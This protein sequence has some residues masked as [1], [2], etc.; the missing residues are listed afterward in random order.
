MAGLLA[1]IGFAS[2]W[3]FI[4]YLQ[5]QRRNNGDSLKPKL[6]PYF[7]E[8]KKIILPY[9]NTEFAKQIISKSQDVLK[10]LENLYLSFNKQGTFKETDLCKLIIENY[11]DNFF[12]ETFALI[13]VYAFK[14]YYG[15]QPL[16]AEKFAHKS[17]Q[18]YC[19]DKLLNRINKIPDIFWYEFDIEKKDLTNDR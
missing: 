19:K 18:K 2:I 15:I 5:K 9:Q 17:V 10:E 11:N 16:E 1:L 14:P 3:I 13:F 7:D 8:I 6:K 12:V 4:E